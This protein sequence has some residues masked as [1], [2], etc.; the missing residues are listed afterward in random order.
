M[1]MCFNPISKRRFAIIARLGIARLAFCRIAMALSSTQKNK[2]TKVV[3]RHDKDT[4]S[5][6]YQI[7]LL[8]EEIK[9]LTL[10]LKKNKKDM[11]SRRGLLKKVANRRR[12]MGYLKRTKETAYAKLIKKLG[13]KG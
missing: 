7:A 4:G 9:K 3:R 2:A 13:I 6:E 10:H 5:P 12:L 1:N 8:T 11:H